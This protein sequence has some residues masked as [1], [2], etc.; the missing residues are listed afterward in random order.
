MPSCYLVEAGIAR[1]SHRLKRDYP[2]LRLLLM[3]WDNGFYSA[4][5]LERS[6]EVAQKLDL[7]HIRYKPSLP[8][9]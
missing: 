7:E 6:L 1:M 9:V 3:T 8:C 2:G 5:A 4:V